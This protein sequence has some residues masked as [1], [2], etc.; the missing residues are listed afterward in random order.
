M[1]FLPTNVLS[2]ILGFYIG[3]HEAKAKIIAKAWTTHH[4]KNLGRIGRPQLFETSYGWAANGFTPLARQKYQD[5]FNKRTQQVGQFVTVCHGTHKN[6]TGVIIK[7]SDQ[8]LWCVT[9]GGDLFRVGRTSVGDAMKWGRRNPTLLHL[10]PHIR[11][12]PSW[13]GRWIFTGIKV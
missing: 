6:K 9:C 13:W 1:T 8:M 7:K 12:V 4:R 5:A 3:F 10:T 11:S 2:N